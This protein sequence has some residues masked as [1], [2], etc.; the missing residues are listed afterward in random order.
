MAT[1]KK[2]ENKVKGYF[3]MSINNDELN[4]DCAGEDVSLAA[5]F[6]MLITSKDK[7]HASIKRILSAAIEFAIHELQPKEKNSSKKSNIV[8]KTPTKAVKKK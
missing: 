3:F 2:I 1:S 4:I 8:P 5:A 7:K 6:G